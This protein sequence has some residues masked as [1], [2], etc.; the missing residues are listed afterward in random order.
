MPSLGGTF[1]G[2]YTVTS[3]TQSGGVALANL[4][5]TPFSQ[6]ASLQYTFNFTQSVDVISG[7]FFM[8]TIE[9]DNITGT[10][11]LGGNLTFESRASGTSARA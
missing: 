5:G 2:T 7:R 9:F 11:G 3:C 8:G 10:I 6:G 1:T 4:C